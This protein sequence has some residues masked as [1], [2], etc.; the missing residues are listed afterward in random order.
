MVPLFQMFRKGS[1]TGTQFAAADFSDAVRIGTRKTSVVF[2]TQQENAGRTVA[3]KVFM[4][5]L[6]DPG[7]R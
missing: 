6:D 4:I 7:T 1:K 2:S 5:E 3:L